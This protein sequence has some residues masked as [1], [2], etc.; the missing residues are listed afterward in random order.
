MYHKLHG[1][2]LSALVSL[3]EGPRGRKQK[4]VPSAEQRRQR[5]CELSA[6]E[7]LHLIL[8]RVS[9]ASP[10]PLSSIHRAE[11]IITSARLVYAGARKPTGLQDAEAWVEGRTDA[12]VRLRGDTE[13]GWPLRKQTAVGRY[14]QV[15]ATRRELRGDFV[16]LLW[17]PTL[18]GTVPPFTGATFAS[19]W[20]GGMAQKRVGP[21]ETR[22][23]RVVR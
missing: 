23:N 19:S 22:R 14:T 16:S 9:R 4:E 1:I 2:R 13:K 7:H 11:S 20:N 21:S 6:C 5:E 17:G 3:V 18:F 8:R 10:M 12:L 15:L